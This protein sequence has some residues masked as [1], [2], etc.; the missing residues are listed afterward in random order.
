MS[1]NMTSFPNTLQPATTLKAYAPISVKPADGL[2]DLPRSRD[3][4]N[5]RRHEHPSRGN[6]AHCSGLQGTAGVTARRIVA[7]TVPATSIFDV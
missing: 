7:E 5:I 6:T 2:R 4:M 1:D 3:V